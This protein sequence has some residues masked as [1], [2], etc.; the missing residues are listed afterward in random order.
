MQGVPE[1]RVS[2]NR[3]HRCSAPVA[4][5][6]GGGVH[7]DGLGTAEYGKEPVLPPELGQGNADCI[8]GLLCCRVGLGLGTEN[9]HRL[10]NALA[11]SGASSRQTAAR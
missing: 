1:A 7:R 11:S 8:D 3:A 4:S 5:R 6:G 2:G 10:A 9:L